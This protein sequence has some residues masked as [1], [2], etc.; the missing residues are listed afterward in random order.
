MKNQNDLIIV[1]VCAVL[2]LGT[3]LG[4]YFTRPEPTAP[5]APAT[6]PLGEPTVQAGTVVRGNSLPGGSQAAGAGTGAAA[7]AGAGDNT[8][9]NEQL[10]Q[11]LGGATMMAGG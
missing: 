3:G 8:V 11:Q 10:R 2:L 7:G 9:N 5:A 6:V 1:I 4:F